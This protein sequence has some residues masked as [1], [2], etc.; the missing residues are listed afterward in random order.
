MQ[1]IMST[2]QKQLAERPVLGVPSNTFD[3]SHSSKLSINF[4]TL[5]P[6]T[7][8]EVLPGDSFHITP[9]YMARFQ[10][11]I[12]PA[13]HKF[14]LRSETFF[15]PNRILWPNWEKFIS[16]EVKGTIP[17]ACPVIDLYGVPIPANSLPNYLGLPVCPVP[18]TD[19][20]ALPFAAYQK[21]CNDWYRDED[22]TPEYFTPLIDGVQVGA[23]NG[24][25]QILR[26][27]NWDLDY[28]TTAKPWPQ[29]GDDVIIP[30]SNGNGLPISVVNNANAQIFRDTG[31]GAISGG[32]AVST[33]AGTGFLSD[34]AHLNYI[35]PNG[36]LGISQ[37]DI[38]ANAGTIEE[39][40]RAVAIQ[41][42]LEADARGGTRYVETLKQHFGVYSSDQRMQRPEYI[43]STSQP[44]SISEVVQTSE[45]ASTPQGT[46][47]G[48]G[49]SMGRHDSFHYTAEEHGFLITMVSVLPATGYYQGVPKM[50]VRPT[51]LDYAWPEYAELGEQAILN[52]EVFFDPA[53]AK[54][55]F[56]YVPRYNEYRTQINRVSGTFATSLDFWHDDRKFS[57]T[58]ALNSS[59][60]QC[61][62][63]PSVQRIFA[64]ST[65]QQ[66]L[67][68]GA[69]TIHVNRKLPRVV[70][71]SI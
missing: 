49:V 33:Q 23:P 61:V 48:H 9:E 28:F 8:L 58:P 71:P 2:G 44:I 47:A 10:A 37:S 16:P 15:V 62:A 46:M 1:R 69:F 34:G 19:A 36:T 42:F 54:Q 43:G 60:I 41:K 70:L 18:P 30:I 12:S 59:F 66:I 29:K 57:S 3:L 56:G 7:I 4:G 38:L 25:L 53:T 32:A 63:D 65:G 20:S 64:T 39:L 45:T 51:R 5:Y 13:F 52:E 27:R 50:F 40:R 17:P 68:Y 22:L 35:D 31:T 14:T 55:P 21:V 6:A 26:N 67:I 11:L 24:D